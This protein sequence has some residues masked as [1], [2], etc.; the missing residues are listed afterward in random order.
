MDRALV[1]RSMVIRTPFFNSLW[2]D[3]SG[4]LEHGILR[5]WERTWKTYMKTIEHIYSKFPIIPSSRTTQLYCHWLVF[6]HVNRGDVQN[7]LQGK[8]IYR[9]Q[10]GWDPMVVSPREKVT[11]LSKWRA[12]HSWHRTWRN[13][14]QE[15]EGCLGLP[16]RCCPPSYKWLPP[17]TSGLQAHEYYRYIYHKL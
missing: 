17:V 8:L 9:P 7:Q 2:S 13:Y 10:F 5:F 6:L 1:S 11:R 3:G 4:S 14:V 12:L 16:T 15:I